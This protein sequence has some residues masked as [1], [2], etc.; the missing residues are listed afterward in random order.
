MCDVDRSALAFN[1]LRF[2]AS[3]DEHSWTMQPD[4]SFKCHLALDLM[5]TGVSNLLPLSFFHVQHCFSY[6]WTCLYLFFCCFFCF[7]LVGCLKVA[8]PIPTTSSE[9]C[10]LQHLHLWDISLPFQRNFSGETCPIGVERGTLKKKHYAPSASTDLHSRQLGM[11]W[12]YPLRRLWK[13]PFLAVHTVENRGCWLDLISLHK[14][15]ITQRLRACTRTVLSSFLTKR[16]QF[17]SGRQLNTG[18]PS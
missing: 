7:W 2:S 3:A 11:E 10:P 15:S 12:Q 1:Y 16:K 18:L 8:L 5:N 9:T 14:A 13:V 17:S 6:K 4:H